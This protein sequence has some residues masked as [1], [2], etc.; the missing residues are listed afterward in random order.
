MK[1]YDL[2]IKN[3]AVVLADKVEACTIA[4]KDGRIAAL[5]TVPIDDGEA[6]E[7]LDAKGLTVMPGAVD[8][9]THLGIYRRR[10]HNDV[11]F[12]HRRPLHEQN[13]PLP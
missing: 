9:H 13:R 11:V 8:C 6:A 2:L 12:P 4:V 1:K 10:H 7:V 5:S 3:G